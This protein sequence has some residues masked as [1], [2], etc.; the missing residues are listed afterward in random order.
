MT[1][2]E[3]AEKELLA[4]INKYKAALGRDVHIDNIIPIWIDSN[5]SLGNEKA[6]RLEV[7]KSKYVF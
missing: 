4:A 2:I 1:N 5:V 7:K 6:I 3:I